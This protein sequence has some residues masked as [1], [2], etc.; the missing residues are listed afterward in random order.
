MQLVMPHNLHKVKFYDD[1]VPLFTRYQI[2]SQIETAFVREVQLPSG[3]AIVI[4]HTEA[5]LSVDIN[6]ARATKGGDIEETA[7]NTN[8]EAAEEIARQLRLRDLGGLIV[9]DFIDMTSPKN[10]REVENTL[11]DALK[12]DRARVQV[13]RISRFGL[14][15]MS[16]QRLRPSLGESSQI[17]CPRCTGQGTIRGTESLALS[18][19]RIIEED[20]MKENTGRIV[21][22]LPV[23][24]A[25]YLLNEKRQSISEIEQRQSIA[26]VIVPNN[27]LET[28]HYEIQ[29]I[30]TS[31]M[32]QTETAS[33]YELVSEFKEEDLE[34]AKESAR[35]KVEEPAVKGVVPLQ[36]VPQQKPQVV[37]Q[38]GVLKRLWSNLF[39]SAGVTE[40]VKKPKAAPATGRKSSGEEQKSSRPSTSGQQRPTSR[41]KQSRRA[42]G[43]KSD[44][45]K[46]DTRKPRSGGSQGRSQP[47][48]GERSAKTGETATPADVKSASDTGSTDTSADQSQRS[49]GSRR[50]K[51]G[52]RRRRREP[53][54]DDSGPAKSNAPQHQNE[55]RPDQATVSSS[56]Q[57]KESTESTAP[58]KTMQDSDSPSAV[59]PSEVKPMR[60]DASQNSTP[61]RVTDPV[62]KTAPQ[63][64]AQQSLPLEPIQTASGN[65]TPAAKP[66]D[67]N[68]DTQSHFESK[69]STA[70]QAYTGGPAAESTATTGAT[71]PKEASARQGVPPNDAQSLTGNTSP[72]TAN[73]QSNQQ[74]ATQQ[75]SEQPHGQS[76]SYSEASSAPT[77]APISSGTSAPAEERTDTERDLSTRDEAKNGDENADIVKQHESRISKS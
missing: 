60:E 61:S 2:E 9:I 22:Q 68:S 53:G 46:P 1:K 42:E 74:S 44:G 76:S 7:L 24:V 5:L 45:R 38:E 49:A 72:E 41:K 29:R 71:Q 62:E 58:Q 39:G 69:P 34:L 19:L 16:R 50:G 18:I 67:V 57:T 20:A 12:M 23:N 51:R 3:G 33:S 47:P 65:N 32:Q 73:Q 13:G 77:I 31:E 4:D 75:A 28:P 52:G 15:E 26:I 30:K 54:S 64:S 55:A 35:E 17:I 36:P 70:P 63:Q 6:S 59:T 8:K 25:T 43:R 27:N 37:A 56:N 11:K 66:S 10:Q 14:L 48:S 40:E 21:V